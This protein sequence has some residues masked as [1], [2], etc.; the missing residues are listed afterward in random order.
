MF[1]FNP[2][3]KRAPYLFT[4]LQVERYPS[5]AFSRVLDKCLLVSL[6]SI[7]CLETP[8]NVRL[9]QLDEIADER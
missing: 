6:T 9:P 1:V 7:E 4:L 5:F 3:W 8:D 2:F